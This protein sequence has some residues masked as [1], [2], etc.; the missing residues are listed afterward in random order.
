[1]NWPIE[2]LYLKV[3]LPSVKHAGSTTD[4]VHIT[5]ESLEWLFHLKLM[6]PV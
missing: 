1:M 4:G 6:L 5:C 3:T 2:Q